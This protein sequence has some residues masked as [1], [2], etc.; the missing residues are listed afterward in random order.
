MRIAHFAPFAPGRCGMY[1]TVREA[2]KAARLL[3]H[4]A[5]LVDT[6]VGKARSVGAIDDRLGCRVVA[7]NYDEVEDY[8]LFVL[9]SGAPEIGRAHV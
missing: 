5:E 8:D 2:I 1:E 3:G 4:T 9:S 6:G 7:R